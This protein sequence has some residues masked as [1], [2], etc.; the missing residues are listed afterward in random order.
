MYDFL[1]IVYSN[2]DQIHNLVE[3]VQQCREFGNILQVRR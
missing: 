1:L 2:D 3:F